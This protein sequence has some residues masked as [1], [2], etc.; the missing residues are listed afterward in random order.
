MK[1]QCYNVSKNFILKISYEDFTKTEKDQQYWVNIGK[2][3]NTKGS[4]FEDALYVKKIYK[5]KTYYF[6]KKLT[7]QIVKDLTNNKKDVQIHKIKVIN[8]PYKCKKETKYENIAVKE[9]YPIEYIMNNEVGQLITN[10][11]NNPY[12]ILDGDKIKISS[13]RLILYKLKGYTCVKCGLVGQYLIKER[14]ND[15]ESYH[16]ELYSKDKNGNYVKFTKDHILPKSK[17]GADNINN[18]QTMCANCNQEKG[19]N[20]P[21]K[22]KFNGMSELEIA[23]EK[24][25]EIYQICDKYYNS[26]LT[27]KEFINKVRAILSNSHKI[28]DISILSKIKRIFKR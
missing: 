20:E 16:L 25:E 7:E 4:T 12:I 8:T 14:Y 21:I 1:I 28:K 15:Q 5:G 24:I 19:N 23:K 10:H 17:G 6:G 27:V 13:D 3:L 22:D 2:E 18:Y 11:K 9:I 26:K